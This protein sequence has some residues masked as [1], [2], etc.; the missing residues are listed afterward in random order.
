MATQIYNTLTPITADG[1][2][3][4][5]LDHPDDQY[6]ISVDFS[7]PGSAG[8]ITIKDSN[9]N[10]YYQSGTALTVAYNHVAGGTNNSFIVTPIGG[11][12]IYFTAASFAGSPVAKV[13]WNRRKT[14][15]R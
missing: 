8:T 6:D 9:E 2:Y 4:I 7:T 13:Y 5:V 14:K 1:D 12:R 11:N 10:V 15:V 3:F